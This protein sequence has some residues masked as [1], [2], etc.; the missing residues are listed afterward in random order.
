[1]KQK[2]LLKSMLLLFALIAGSS[3]V[4]ATDVTYTISSKNTL[5]TTGAAPTG[6][7]AS[8]AETYGTSKQMTS[9]NSQTLTLTGYN[10]YKITQIKLSMK[11][12]QSGGAGKLSY[13]TDNGANYSYIIGSSQSGVAFNQT[14]WNG[15]W[16]TSYVDVTK[17]GLNISCGTS[18]VI[19]KVEATAN[20]LYCQSYTLT[21]EA[22]DARTATTI[23][24][25]D[26]G[27]TN[28]NKFT[29]TDAGLLT[30]TVKAGESAIGGASVTWSSATTSVATIDE[31]T[32]AVTLVGEGS[33]V[34][35]AS[36]AG[37]V[38]YK[39]STK[40]YNL[41]VINENPALVSIWSEDFSSFSA[42]DVPDAGTYGY[43]CTNGGGTTKIYEDNNAGGTS[44]EL[45]VGKSNGTFTATIPL[46]TSTY[47]YSGDLTLSFRSNAYSVNVN[48]TT[49]GITVDGEANAGEGK[50]FNTKDTHKITFKGVTT[51][52]ENITIVF[53]ATTSS[54]VR[55]DDIVLKGVQAAITKAAT[56]VISPASGAVASGTE[57]TVTCLTG[58]ATIYYTTDGST[59]TSSST[60]YNPANKP[61][62]TAAT[63]FKAIAV[64]DGLTDSD[65]A[66][67]TYT[68][69][70]PCAT[71]TFSPVAGEVEKGTT[72]TISTETDGATIYYTTDGSTP[73]ASSSVYSSAI[74]INTAQTLKAIAV[75]DGMANSEV[76]SASYTII[77]YAA[78]PFSWNDKSTPTGITNSGVGTYSSAPYLKFDDSGDNIILKINEAPGTLTFDI[79][80]NSFSGGTFKV[81]ASADGTAY[82]DLKV[83]TSLGS[84]TSERFIL[85]STVRYIKWVYTTKSSG[86]V[87]LGN[88]KLTSTITLKPAKEYTTLISPYAL[89]FSGTSIKP[90]IVKDD[91]ANDGYVT[92]TKVSKVPANTGLILKAETLNAEVNIPVLASTADDMTG[93]LM[94]GSATATTAVAA[95][96]GYILKNGVFQPSSGGDLPAGKA[97]LNIAVSAPTLTLDFGGTTGIKSVDNGQVTVDSYYNLAGQRVAQPTKGL[98]I[99]NGKKV[100]L[101]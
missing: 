31:N 19:I 78:L 30:A 62:I 85:A 63:T 50:T 75:K 56:P 13:S 99:V 6:S 14:A 60:A 43:S 42:E 28:T 21:Y 36:Y 25:D 67:A 72:V 10:G 4:W 49:D 82:S 45:L 55:I 86:N 51:E 12:N 41:T 24:I 87:A 98:Y 5:T 58:G 16:S 97:Y 37:N 44:P 84:K 57:V 26:S 53:T 39:P 94:A 81:Q 15:S 64:K 46:V 88:I 17:S 40:T 96:A 66:T 27:I 23:T 1:M 20:S 9:G 68:L 47:G 89:D 73:T 74:T 71:P 92:L 100:I 77:D 29:G 59:P 22:D 52:T 83:Y 38:T 101:K 3:S 33:T 69:A 76:A 90:Y 95:N 48:T 93:N 7:S 54:N 34:I 91:N 80:G 79:Q 35:T 65:V 70:A 18:N 11:S 8:I 2:L 32:G 61:T